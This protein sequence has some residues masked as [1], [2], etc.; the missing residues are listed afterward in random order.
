MVEVNG[1]WRSPYILEKHKCQG[2]IVTLLK[3]I[4]NL[5]AAMGDIQ[6]QELLPAGRRDIL[7][8][9]GDV[10]EDLFQILFHVWWYE[11]LNIIEH[12]AVVPQSGILAH[13]VAKLAAMTYTN[14]ALGWMTRVS[15]IWKLVL[16]GEDSWSFILFKAHSLTTKYEV[17]N[18]SATINN[19]ANRDNFKRILPP[20]VITASEQ[21]ISSSLPPILLT[22]P[23][24]AVLCRGLPTLANFLSLYMS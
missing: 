18:K 17:I 4:N 8:R 1:I 15:S 5:F 20:V 10:W 11:G 9:Q 3:N 19:V 24:F 23:W 13:I 2:F 6:W 12:L 21:L 22:Q 7:D 16:E 14:E